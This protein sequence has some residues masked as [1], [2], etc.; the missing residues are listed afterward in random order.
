[1]STFPQEDVL[2]PAK[3]RCQVLTDKTVLLTRVFSL[4]RAEFL[5]LAKLEVLFETPLEES[6]IVLSVVSED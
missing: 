1:M 6:W 5:D 3:L 4:A 2:D